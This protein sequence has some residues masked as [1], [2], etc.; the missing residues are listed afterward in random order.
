MVAILEYGTGLA[1][2]EVQRRWEEPLPKLNPAWF[3]DTL[4]NFDCV[5]VVQVKKKQLIEQEMKQITKYLEFNTLRMSGEIVALHLFPKEE[6][7]QATNANTSKQP[8][9]WDT[10]HTTSKKIQKGEEKGTWVLRELCTAA[11]SVSCVSPFAKDLLTKATTHFKGQLRAVDLTTTFV[12][13][14][15]GSWYVYTDYRLLKQGVKLADDTLYYDPHRMSMPGAKKPTASCTFVG[16]KYLEILSGAGSPDR[17]VLCQLLDYPCDILNPGLHW[18]TRYWFM[19]ACLAE[20]TRHHEWHLLARIAIDL[21]G[22]GLLPWRTLVCEELWAPQTLDSVNAM[23]FYKAHGEPR[24]DNWRYVQRC[25]ALI[26][27]WMMTKHEAEAPDTGFE[28]WL[29]E[30]L[31]T[32]L[33]ALAASV[34]KTYWTHVPDLSTYQFQIAPP[35]LVPGGAPSKPKTG[36]ALFKERIAQAEEEAMRKRQEALV[37]T[38]QS[39]VRGFLARQ[40]LATLS[41]AQQTPNG[42]PPP[43]TNENPQ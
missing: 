5:A 23:H 38:L 24:H 43:H 4:A 20:S 42:P 11:Q 21:Y 13:L 9:L 40:Q 28:E 10:A 27:T 26:V 31:A 3:L 39:A 18:P 16:I 25:I 8:T 33:A 6:K 2:N 1:A 37:V 19:V 22:Q 41:A 30:N 32:K 12:P 17:T 29:H 36:L 7:P 15:G 35:P 14:V 34:D